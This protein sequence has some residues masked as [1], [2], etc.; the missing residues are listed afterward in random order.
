MKKFI[1]VLGVACLFGLSAGVV[2]AGECNAK[3]D[4]LGE[5]KGPEKG[6]PGK[7]GGEMFVKADADGN[8][9]LSLAEFTAMQAKR[10]E[11]R[12]EKMGDK[13]DPKREGKRPSVEERF[14]K[15]DANA[16]G[17]LTKEELAAGRQ[18]KGGK[19]GRGHGKGGPEGGKEGGP[20][21]E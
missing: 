5:G 14:A 16:D 2:L 8:G 3:G 9:T 6:G 15:L 12:K 11:M 18:G 7:K 21:K 20:A 17:Q 10:E 19:G 1:T 13:A 4:G